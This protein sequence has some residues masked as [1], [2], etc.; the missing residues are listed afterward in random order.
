MRRQGTPWEIAKANLPPEI[1]DKV[2]AGEFA[3]DVQETTDLTVSAAE[4]PVASATDSCAARTTSSNALTT[5]GETGGSGCA[6]PVSASC[7]ALSCAV[8]RIHCLLCVCSRP[9]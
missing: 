9:A 3:F 6:S 8:L 5:D 1:L 2:K 7:V 4:M